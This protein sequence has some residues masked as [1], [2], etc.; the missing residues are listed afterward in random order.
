MILVRTEL[1]CK[2]GRTQEVIDNF[3]AMGARIDQQNVIKSSRIMTDLSGRFDTVI[4]ESEIESLDAYFEMLHAAFA[5]PEM[6]AQQAA[7]QGDAPYQV[8]ARNFYTIVAE[9]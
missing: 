4:I 6:Q 2:W 7:L 8:G 9:F 1:H 5:D 3:K